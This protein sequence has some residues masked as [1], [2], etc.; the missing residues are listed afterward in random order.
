[1]KRGTNFWRRR[2]EQ[3]GEIRLIFNVLSWLGREQPHLLN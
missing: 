1:M 2:T 3:R